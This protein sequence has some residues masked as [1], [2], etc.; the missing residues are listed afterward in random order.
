MLEFGWEGMK[1]ML[2]LF[3]SLCGFGVV[4]GLKYPVIGM[5]GGWPAAAG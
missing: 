2:F 4:G 1:Y 3:V 5:V